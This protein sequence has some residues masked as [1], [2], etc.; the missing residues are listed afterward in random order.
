MRLS[1]IILITLFGGPCLIAQQITD[2]LSEDQFEVFQKHSPEFRKSPN[3]LHQAVQAN[4]ALITQFLLDEDI[5]PNQLDDQQLS[6]LHYAVQQNN[7]EIL[8]VLLA[9][10]A[11]VDIP[12]GGEL[13]ATPLMWACAKEDAKVARL[14][15]QNG[16][17]LNAIDRQGDPVINWAAYYGHPEVLKLLVEKGVDVSVQSKHGDAGDVLLRLWHSDSLLEIFHS[18]S[19]YQSPGAEVEAIFSQTTHKDLLPL[20]K[21]LQSG[22]F[23]DS[24]DGFGNGLIH[25]AASLGQVD[26]LELLLKHGANLNLLNRVGQSALCIA[27]K[28][29][30]DATVKQ[31][32][33]AGADVN[34]TDTLYA[35]SALIGGVVGGDTSLVKIL[36]EA[37]AQLDH[38]EYVNQATALHWAI[39]YQNE[40]M[41]L[42]LL[43]AGA[44]WKMSL[45]NNQTT[46]TIE[47]AE[48]MGMTALTAKLKGFQ[49][50]LQ[51]LSGSWKM[52]QIAYLYPD[53]TYLIDA[54]A[55]GIFVVSPERYVIQ[56]H[57]S[58]NNRAPFADFT[59]P[60]CEE[61]RAAF[62]GLV[63]NTGQFHLTDSLFIAQPNIARVP[64][65]EG[66]RQ[67]YNYQI[68]RQQLVLTL[69]DEQYPDGTRPDWVGKISV[70]FTLSKE[71]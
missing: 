3:I 17:N 26:L 11:A 24:R 68:S 21:L 66:A 61:L 56:Y 23:A 42:L 16:A 30:D 13:G 52:E 70:R 32:L 12:S 7:S 62:Q 22:D 65:F 60:T 25:R 43:Q 47:L 29:G 46:T 64:G 4:A 19:I 45:F 41:A 59:N 44:N 38:Q 57:P 50:H 31:L 1:F 51:N 10:G 36:I 37:G 15:L 49:N 6:P 55:P 9:A 27:A 39:F 5:D 48:N 54:P 28:N 33:T 67:V 63:F 2:I 18:T 69:E 8:A 35:L 40:A 53:T 58:K 71:E 34:A 20:D 14:L